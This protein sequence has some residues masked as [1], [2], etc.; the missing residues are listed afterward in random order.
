M[1]VLF[2]NSVCGSGV[3]TCRGA[4]PEPA[5]RAAHEVGEVPKAEGSTDLAQEYEAQGW[6]VKNW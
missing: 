3:E 1:K 5:R 4:S 2:I 6:E